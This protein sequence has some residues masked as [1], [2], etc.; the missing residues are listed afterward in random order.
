MFLI[1]LAFTSIISLFPM[2]FR[3]STQSKNRF[4]ASAVGNGILEEVRAYP[5]RV[6]LPRELLRPRVCE[7]VIEGV[8]TGVTFRVK[9]IEFSPSNSERNGPDPAS[10][11]CEV[12]VMIEWEEGT[13]ASSEKKNLSMVFNGS[14]SR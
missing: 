8:R 9:S 1:A 10:H 3:Q 4:L 14:K 12:A 6:P 5:Y 13:S 7:Q 11:A 2:L